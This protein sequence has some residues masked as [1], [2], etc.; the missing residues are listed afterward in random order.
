MTKLVLLTTLVWF[1]NA[2]AEDACNFNPWTTYRDDRLYINGENTAYAFRSSHIHLDADGAP[3]AY[4]PDDMALHCTRGEGF[5]G[6]DCPANAG[7]PG[8]SWWHTVLVPDPGNPGKAYVQ[9]SGDFA[10]YFVSK[11]SLQDTVVDDITDPRR[12]VDSTSVSYFV[13]PRSF[14]KRRG[15]GL[16][17]DLGYALNTATGEKT[18][19]VVADIGPSN[20][21]L[22]EM[23]LHMAEALGG[24]SP[25][26]RTGTG[27]PSGEILYMVFPYS[28]RQTPWPLSQA[29]I[30]QAAFSLL[31]DNG[32]FEAIS[33][34]R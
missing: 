13:F 20:A 10:G 4:H 11:T 3:N 22:G 26:A 28:S 21:K 27:T 15:T 31:Q 23:S 8:T 24:E 33:G 6:L 7:Y 9:T 14:Y 17:G 29:E 19:F 32:G 5:K 30:E 18:S 1:A 2:F 25:N 16:I 12:Y 34:C